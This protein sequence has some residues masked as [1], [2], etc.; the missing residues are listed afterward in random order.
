[1]AVVK[2]EYKWRTVNQ[3]GMRYPIVEP[4][5]PG[6]EYLL[7]T[8]SGTVS[9][10]DYG[11]VGFKLEADGEDL[12]TT[13]MWASEFGVHLTLPTS[14]R[15]VN[16]TKGQLIYIQVKNHPDPAIANNTVIGN[17]DYFSITIAELEQM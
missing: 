17:Q 11:F 5:T 4:Y 1:M 14:V 7:V 3:I 16:V 9:A 15:L 10:N 13:E 8:V 12:G 2:K 6:E